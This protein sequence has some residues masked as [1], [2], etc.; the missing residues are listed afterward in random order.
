VDVIGIYSD[1]VAI[2]VIGQTVLGAGSYC[3]LILGYVILGELSEDKFKQ[4]GIITLNAV[5]AIGEMLIGVLYF[6]YNQWSNYLIIFL[7]IPQVGLLLFG[8][9]F[10]VE[11]PYYHLNKKKDIRAALTSMQKVATLNRAEPRVM[12]EVEA[13]FHLVVQANDEQARNAVGQGD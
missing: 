10:L 2:I 3:V 4:V 5:W 7:L 1:V 11:S 8:L 9:F 12:E 13:N 6:W